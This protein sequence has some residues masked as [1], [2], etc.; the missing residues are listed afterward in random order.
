MTAKGT[1]SNEVHTPPRGSYVRE[2]KILIDGLSD[3][4]TFTTSLREI[5]HGTASVVECGGI[6]TGTATFY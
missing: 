2:K 5:K 3:N 1:I 4:V 6:I